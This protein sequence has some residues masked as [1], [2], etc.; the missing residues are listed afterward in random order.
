M[1]PPK[2]ESAAVNHVGR[3]SLIV[4]LVAVV[5]AAKQLTASRTPLQLLHVGEQLPVV[6]QKFAA[7]AEIAADQAVQQEQ[8]ASLGSIDA[9]QPHVPAMHDPQSI[10]QHV[11]ENHRRALRGLPSAGS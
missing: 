1:P 9:G 10:Q 2:L 5:F 4:K 8:L 7:G 6:L 11:F 3:D